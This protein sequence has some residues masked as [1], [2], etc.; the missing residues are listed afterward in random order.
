VSAA[1]PPLCA[2]HRPSGRRP[3]RW[4]RTVNPPI[5]RYNVLYWAFAYGVEARLASL[6]TLAEMPVASAALA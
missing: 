1:E 2:G 5:A 3:F 4:Q 6:T